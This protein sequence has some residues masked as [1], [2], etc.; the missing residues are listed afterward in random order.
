MKLQ[1]QSAVNLIDIRDTKDFN[2]VHLKNAL[3]VPFSE[4]LN[5]PEM[6]KLQSFEKDIV[7]Y[8]NS[9]VESAKA[10]TL[11]TQMGFTKLYILD[12]PGELISEN[13]LDKD[14]VIESSEILKYK[15]QP[16]TLVR[17]E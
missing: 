14:S 12:I 4:I 13:I 5:N 8:S 1:N 3:N 6:E 9:T 2:Q 11:L 16:D 15:F 17:L 10:W 7:L